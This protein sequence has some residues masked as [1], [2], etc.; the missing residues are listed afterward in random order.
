MS[1][2]RKALV[3]AITLHSCLRFSL[4]MI[5]QWSTKHCVS[6]IMLDFISKCVCIIKWVCFQNLSRTPPSR[7]WASRLITWA[8]V[9]RY[10]YIHWTLNLRLTDKWFKNWPSLVWRLTE[11]WI[12][13]YL[14]QLI[15][16]QDY[17]SPSRRPSFAEASIET[18]TF[19]STG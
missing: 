3:V 14:H 15:A 2:R 16:L 5:S 4:Y 19:C 18:I 1:V 13:E 17:W 8:K 10:R 12:S 9:Y 6:F 11:L 7:C